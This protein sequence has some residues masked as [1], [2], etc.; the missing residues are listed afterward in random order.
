MAALCDFSGAGCEKKA[1]Q[2]CSFEPSQAPKASAKCGSSSFPLGLHLS[3]KAKININV[4]DFSLFHVDF[5]QIC[6]CNVYIYIIVY[7]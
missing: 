2:I 5:M 3:Y 7:I 1:N 6:L 4:Y